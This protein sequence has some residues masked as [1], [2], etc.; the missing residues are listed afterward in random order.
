[1][2]KQLLCGDNLTVLSS[3]DTASVD[4]IYLDPP[5]NSNRN[6]SA[7]IGSEAAGAAFKDTWTM[8]DEDEVWLDELKDQKMPMH[9]IITAAGQIH[10]KGM[11]S[12]LT[13]MCTR[14]IEMKRVLK[15]TGSIYLHVDPTASHYLKILMDSIFRKDNFQNEIVWQY[16]TGGISKKHF[17]R[18]HDNILFYSQSKNKHFQ[19]LREE[20]RDISRFNK[21]DSNGKKYYEKSGNK[22]YADKGVA[23]TD[24]WD[25]P[26]VRNVSKERTGYPTQKPLALL[27]RII[28]ASSNQGDI[29]LDPFC[30]CA[31]TCV[32][33]EQLDRQW[34]GIDISPNAI[35]IAR[36]RLKEL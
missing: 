19:L 8:T 10:G 17:A 29:V 27:H 31:T 35:E 3:M 18:K 21:I 33:A 26:P 25:I 32:A 13:M 15:D 4:L 6:Y 7:P 11:Q 1:M 20:T 2:L 12:Y 28:K 9:T 5:F 34:I 14:L 16:R 24:I 22:Y 23:M 30:G 36:D